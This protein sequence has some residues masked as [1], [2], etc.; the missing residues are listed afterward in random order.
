MGE[1]V[2]QVP[3]GKRRILEAQLLGQH[4]ETDLALL[5]IDETD[6]PTFPSSASSVLM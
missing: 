2:G 6:L 5:K 3:I 4:K 1:S